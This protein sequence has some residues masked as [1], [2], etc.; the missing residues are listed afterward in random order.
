M[1]TII[2]YEVFCIWLL[3]FKIHQHGSGYHCVPF[4]FMAAWYAT[5]VYRACVVSLLWS[6]F[7]SV[8]LVIC[9]WVVLLALAFGW[10][11]A[12]SKRWL[13]GRDVTEWHVEI[14]FHLHLRT[15]AGQSRIAKKH[16]QWHTEGVLGTSVKLQFSE[17]CA[18]GIWNLHPLLGMAFPSL[19][20]KQ[21]VNRD[22][23]P[24]LEFWQVKEKIIQW[25]FLGWA[26]KGN[27]LGNSQTDSCYGIT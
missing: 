7:E 8:P 27:D 5:Y 21:T 9:D 22:T 14:P 24:G 10:L 18:A 20:I 11:C 1:N 19:R 26:P 6:Y 12:H 25:A 2:P 4:I 23:N 15:T 3:N 16:L 17:V 13:S